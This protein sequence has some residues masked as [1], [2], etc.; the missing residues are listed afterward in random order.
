MESFKGKI[1]RLVSRPAIGLLLA[2]LRFHWLTQTSHSSLVAST[3]RLTNVTLGDLTL[4][5]NNATS[6]QLR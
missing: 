6:H 2:F 3:T 1:A 4:G 5:Y